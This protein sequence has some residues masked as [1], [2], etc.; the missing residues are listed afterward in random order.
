MVGMRDVKRRVA[1]LEERHD[2]PALLGGFPDWPV[3]DQLESVADLLIWYRR[4]H[5]DHA[6]RYQG[7]DREIHL[8]GVVCAARALAEGGTHTFP[9][10][11]TVTPTPDPDDA[12]LFRVE[13]PRSI[14]LEDLPQEISAYFERMDPEKQPKREQFLY[15]DRHRS[16]KARERTR[17]HE[18]HGWDKPTPE[19]LRY[20]EARGGGG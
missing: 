2:A 18:E 5:S 15:G 14:R 1:R 17:W 10:G 9:S 13:A 3:E 19:H 4:F 11:L 6:V 8:L 20:W 16:K 12:D 7:T